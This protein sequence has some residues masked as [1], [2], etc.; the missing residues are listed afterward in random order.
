MWFCRL[1]NFFFDKVDCY[2][3]V[4]F[5]NCFVNIEKGDFDDEVSSNL[6]SVGIWSLRELFE[7]GG[8][9]VCCMFY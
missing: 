8:C 4:F 6:L 1:G 3:F 2:V 9:S 7:F 5:G